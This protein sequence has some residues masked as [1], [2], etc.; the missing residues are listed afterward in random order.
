M[1]VI[2]PGHFYALASLDGNDEVEW[3]QF[4]KRE[5]EGYPGNVGHHPGTIIQEVL[6]ACIDRVKYVDNQIPDER[7][8]PVIDSLRTAL[9]YLEVRAAERHGKKLPEDLN[10][11]KIEELPVGKNGHFLCGAGA[12]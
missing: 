5:G 6:R 3:L 7:N 10:F 11:H 4:V 2:D 8:R 12:E 9:Y 1:E